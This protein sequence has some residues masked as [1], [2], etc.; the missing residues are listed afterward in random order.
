MRAILLLLLLMSACATQDPPEVAACKAEAN[1]DPEVKSL[2][3]KG[4]G[5]PDFLAE[6]QDNVK[7]ARQRATL[8]CLRARGIIRPGGVERQKPL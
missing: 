8:A 3:L 4:A 6:N 2:L 5:S 1:E 7:A